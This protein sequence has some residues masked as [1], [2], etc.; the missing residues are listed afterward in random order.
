MCDVQGLSP[1]DVGLRMLPQAVA[2]LFL[3]PIIGCWMHKINN[4]LILMAAAVF[5]AGASM[6]LIFLRHDSNYFAYIFPSLI[7]STLA[8]DWVRNVGAVRFYLADLVRCS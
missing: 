3:S 8:M 1:L 2:G 7:L 6:I 4:A 5:Q